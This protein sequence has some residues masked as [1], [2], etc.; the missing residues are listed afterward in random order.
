MQRFDKEELLVLAQFQ[1]SVSALCCTAAF[2]LQSGVWDDFQNWIIGNAVQA[3]E[4]EM[5]TMLGM[6]ITPH[7]VAHSLAEVD[8]MLMLAEGIQAM[9][10]PDFPDMLIRDDEGTAPAPDVE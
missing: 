6:G 3:G 4:D 8:Q 2:V 7:G 9:S 10:N 1:E 5:A